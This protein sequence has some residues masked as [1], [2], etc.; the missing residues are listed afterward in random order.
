MTNS[1]I[2][3]GVETT[4]GGNWNMP[5]EVVIDA[6]TMSISKKGQKQNRADREP[7]LQLGKDVGRNHHP[8]GQI[9]GRV[10][11]RNLP[12]AVNRARSFSRA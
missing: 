12:A 7:G 5:I 1:R 2:F 4:T 9:V 6:V 3:S 11:A 8:H 10:G